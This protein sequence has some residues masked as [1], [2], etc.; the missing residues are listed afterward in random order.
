[1]IL[2]LSIHAQGGKE[3]LQWLK[4]YS[5]TGYFV[6]ND[7]ETRANKP[8]DHKQ[9]IRSTTVPLP[10]VP[11]HETGHMRNMELNSDGDTRRSYYI[12][13]LKDFSIRPNFSPFNSKEMM[14]DIPASLENFQT[15]FYI[16]GKAGVDAASQSGGMIDIMEEW[17]QYIVGL[18]AD[19]EMVACYKANFNTTQNWNDLANDANSSIQSV[20]EFRYFVLRYIMWAQKKYPAT[21]AKIIGASDLKELYTYLVQY[22]EKTA[23]EWIAL[24]TEKNM[25][26]KTKNGFDW[27]WK[28]QVELQ[29]PEYVELEKLMLVTPVR[30]ALNR[31][32]PPGLLGEGERTAVFDLQGRRIPASQ[33]IRAIHVLRG[34]SE[35]MAVLNRPGQ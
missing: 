10:V 24:M 22:A 26:T 11:V 19:V 9:W 4:E 34:K 15:D 31:P 1:M 7:Y 33:A 30:I 17:N 2:S 29:K 8:G 28:F 12:G 25:D 32:V 27:Y 13:N 6:I 3:F 18:K 5:P 35:T 16:S 20:T 21:Y 23:Q 14:A